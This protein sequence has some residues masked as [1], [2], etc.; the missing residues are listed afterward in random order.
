MNRAK[1]TY[2]YADESGNFDFSLKRQASR[3]FIL[4]SVVMNELAVENELLELRRELAWEGVKLS[5][6]TFHATNDK[7]RVRDR[8]FSILKEHDFRVDATILEKRKAVPQIRSTQS[9][10]YGFAWYYHLR[11]VTVETIQDPLELLITAAS[12]GTNEMRTS[13]DSA[14]QAVNNE[15]APGSIM[16]TAMWSAA[17]DPCLQVA[18]YCS[19]A[20]Q[21]KWE[22]SDYRSYDFI[23]DKVGMENDLFSNGTVFYY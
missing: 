18:D 2:I 6:D 12:L 23:K 11:R 21:R 17:S 8:I 13:L 22:R 16:K 14:V 4:T 10:F 15:V 1:R 3:Y 20:I 5:K 19:W 7:Q 9:N